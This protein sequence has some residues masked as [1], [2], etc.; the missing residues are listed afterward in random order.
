MKERMIAAA[1][2]G[3]IAVAVGACVPPELDTQEPP[4]DAGS[5]AGPDATTGCMRA[6]YPPPP[7][8][9]DGPSLDDAVVAVRAIDLGD[10]PTEP[11]GFDLD[12]TCTC[13][14]DAGD[15]CATK[16]AT[17]RCDG[18]GGVD[19]AASELFQLIVDNLGEGFFGSSYYSMA[20]ELGQWSLLLRLSDYNGTPDDPDVRVA[21]FVSPG[22]ETTLPQWDGA[23]AWPISADSVAPNADTT[24][25]LHISNGAY[26]SGGV[27]VATLPSM[28][29]RF[30]GSESTITLRTAGGVLTGKLVVEPGGARID[31]GIIAARWSEKDVFGSLSSFRG[32]GVPVLCNDG[33]FIYNAVKAR[34]CSARD[35]LTDP[36][37]PASS[38]CDALSFGI[39]FDAAPA[40]LGA[41]VPVAAPTPG[42]AP[43]QDPALDSCN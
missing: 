25:P 35:I 14:E 6:T 12:F 24:K 1:L 42:C 2:L 4:A 37:Q 11:P 40:L 32:Q 19:N 31:G 43:D 3:G 41:V 18:T 33:G 20:A 17:P 10:G 26:V 7:S 23:D 29:I 34:V 30:E 27:L 38:P 36:I 5:E 22:F 39:A 15:T 16:L 13:F 21:L 8:V 28:T 9:G